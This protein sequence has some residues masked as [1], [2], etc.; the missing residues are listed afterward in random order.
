MEDKEVI[1]GNLG[2]VG[3]Y[4]VSLK[5]NALVAELQ[6]PLKN[7][8]EMIAKKIGGPIPEDIVQFLE[9]AFSL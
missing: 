6:V 3:S 8:L 9:K 1:G 4:D 5:N 2:V 7:L